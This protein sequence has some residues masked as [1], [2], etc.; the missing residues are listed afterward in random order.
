VVVLSID[1]VG[2]FGRIE[3]VQFDKIPY[4]VNIGPRHRQ[5]GSPRHQHYWPIFIDKRMRSDNVAA[6]AAR[7]DFPYHFYLDRMRTRVIQHDDCPVLKINFN[8]HQ[9]KFYFRMFK[10]KILLETFPLNENNEFLPQYCGAIFGVEEICTLHISAKV[11]G[12]CRCKNKFVSVDITYL[13]TFQHNGG[14]R[15]QSK[16]NKYVTI[17]YTYNVGTLWEYSIGWSMHK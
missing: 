10:W 15:F 12:D 7:Q 2:T 11:G 16:S 6:D 3:R 5:P 9:L 8:K 14:I 1:R 4:H 13:R 17:H